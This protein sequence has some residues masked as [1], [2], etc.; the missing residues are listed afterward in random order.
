MAVTAAAAGDEKNS[1]MSYLCNH[2]IGILCL[3]KHR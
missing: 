1:G 2:S 3:R